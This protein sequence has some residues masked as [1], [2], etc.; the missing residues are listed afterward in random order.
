MENRGQEAVKKLILSFFR[1][2]KMFTDVLGIICRAF[3]REVF[4][5][6]TPAIFRKSIFSQLPDGT[7]SYLRN[8]FENTFPDQKGDILK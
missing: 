7:Y 2:T 3:K 5:P 6:V 4:G 8:R 1:L